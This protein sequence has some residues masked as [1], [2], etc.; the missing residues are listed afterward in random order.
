MICFFYQQERKCEPCKK[1]KDE[2]TS[3]RKSPTKFN[4]AGH[5]IREYRRE[6]SRW[7]LRNEDGEKSETAAMAEGSLTV[8]D[9]ESVK[10]LDLDDDEVQKPRGTSNGQL[11][12]KQNN[13]RTDSPQNQREESKSPSQHDHED[14]EIADECDDDFEDEI[15][16]HCE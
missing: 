12:P 5:N 1:H 15:S 6:V 10:N 11:L 8:S 2:L 16:E 14:E 3:G 9:N 4:S 13:I 7:G